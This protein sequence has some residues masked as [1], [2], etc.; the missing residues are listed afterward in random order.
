MHAF[1][2][3]ATNTDKGGI[4]PVFV[5]YVIAMFVISWRLVRRLSENDAYMAQ[6]AE[7]ID[8]NNNHQN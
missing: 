8:W 2:F 1:D 4:V 6:K 5:I 7:G 3:I